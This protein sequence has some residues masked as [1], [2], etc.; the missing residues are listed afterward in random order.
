MEK[1]VKMET[2]NYSLTGKEVP[3]MCS[4]HPASFREQLSTLRRQF[5]QDGD[6]PFT[7]VL[8]EEVIAQALTAI[9]GWLDRIFSPRK[10]ESGLPLAGELFPAALDPERSGDRVAV[11]LAATPCPSRR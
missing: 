8:T 4:H 3:S 9:S 1:M 2:D 11:E 6:L 7:N 10:C 5:L